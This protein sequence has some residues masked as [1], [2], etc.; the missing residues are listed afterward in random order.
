[1]QRTAAEQ[2]WFVTVLLLV[3]LVLFIDRQ[4]ISLAVEPM[5]ADLNLT[6]S[7]VGML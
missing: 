6:D 3:M 4:I 5:K 1:M 7:E 2:W